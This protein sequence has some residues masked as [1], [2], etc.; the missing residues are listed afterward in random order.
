MTNLQKSDYFILPCNL[1]ERIFF[2]KA[3]TKRVN[4]HKFIEGQ[5]PRHFTT[6]TVY[7][8]K[9]NYLKEKKDTVSFVTCLPIKRIFWVNSVN[10]SMLLSSSNSMQFLA[11]QKSAVFFFL[12]FS[13]FH[14]FFLFLLSFSF[15]LSCLVSSW[16]FSSSE[17]PASRAITHL[18]SFT[19]SEQ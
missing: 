1:V 15:F 10:W 16:K 7:E 18:T 2:S 14:S 5:K 8:L 19:Q 6:K 13:F 9:K 17:K 11:Q 4:L 12:S 3:T